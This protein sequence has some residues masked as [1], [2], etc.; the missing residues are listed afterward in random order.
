ML[1]LLV[2]I[3]A[4][5]LF[6]VQN[7]LSLTMIARH[8]A[9]LKQFVSDNR[10]AALLIYIAVYIVVV[11]LSLPGAALLSLGG[12]VVL[13][14]QLSVPASI[15]AATVGAVIVFQIVKT[16]L[17]S[18]IA[19]RAGPFV[20]K[21]TH[22]FQRDAFNYLLFLRLTPFVPFF[23][24]NA[25]AGLVR[26]DLRTFTLATFIGIIPG[27]LAFAW[28]GSGLDDVLQKSVADFE[29]CMA[30]Q[31]EGCVLKISALSLFSPQFIA[32]LSVLGII[33]L[34]PVGLRLWKQRA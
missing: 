8:L 1:L 4:A 16:S 17:G 13:G 23:A 2:A 22:G 20:Q 9:E 18:S 28:L 29:A 5:Y 11:A 26:V 21:L 27:S 19:E 25:V 31:P 34:I 10:L 15:L 12:A 14:W 3:V 32:G 30:A 24:V 6:G 7:Y 33:A